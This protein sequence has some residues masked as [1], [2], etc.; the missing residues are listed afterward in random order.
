PR[1]RPSG[2]AACCSCSSSATWSTSAR[3]TVAPPS[4]APGPAGAGRDA[5]PAVSPGL[6]A[7][8][9][10]DLR[11]AVTELAAN[12][13]THAGG[14]ATARW[15]V[16]APDELVCE[17]S[18]HGTLTDPLAGRIPASTSAERGRGLLLVQQLCDLVDIRAVDGGTTVRVHLDL[19]APAAMPA[20]RSAPDAAEC[21]L[22]PL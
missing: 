18:S 3:W 20:P 12:A 14:P 21:G 4:G 17:I 9:V 22:A 6:P 7:D 11:I 1:R 19:P 10:D 15:W 16:A 2:D 13:I 5:R 8:R